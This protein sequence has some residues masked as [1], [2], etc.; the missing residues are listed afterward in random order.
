ATG[1]LSAMTSIADDLHPAALTYQYGP[2]VSTGDAVVLKGITDP[3]SGRSVTLSYGT[4]TSCTQTN[5]VRLLCGIQ[6]WDGTSA[7]LQ[8]NANSQLA[9]IVNPG[10]ITTLLGYDA[11]GRLSDI[12]DAVANDVLAAG[13]VGVPTCSDV[14]GTCVLD[15]W[16]GYD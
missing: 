9:K 11:T 5:A 14:A 8:Y 6:Y 10:G 3:V 7:S 4:A 15:T 1:Q 12:R 16:I 13:G 2:A